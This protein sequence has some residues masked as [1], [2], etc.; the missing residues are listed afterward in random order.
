M[1]GG[2]RFHNNLKLSFYIA[3]FYFPWRMGRSLRNDLPWFL[4]GIVTVRN[5]AHDH[6]LEDAV[7]CCEWGDNHPA[8]WP[9]AKNIPQT[10]NDRL[11]KRLVRVVYEKFIEFFNIDIMKITHVM[12]NAFLN[13]RQ[14]GE[15]LRSAPQQYNYQ[16]SGYKPHASAQ[17]GRNVALGD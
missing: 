2:L 14:G 7:A 11:D 6:S 5:H 4:S 17:S 1:S 3:V 10:S 12:R 13:I 15:R 9:K 8:V 16:P